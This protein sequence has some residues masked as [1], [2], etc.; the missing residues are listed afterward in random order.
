MKKVLSVL[1]ISLLILSLSG[2]QA[3]IM[4]APGGPYPTFAPSPSPPP[5]SKV[6][7][8]YASSEGPL[9]NSYH[10]RL[11]EFKLMFTPIDL[12]VDGEYAYPLIAAGAREIG[13]VAVTVA[14]GMLTAQ[15]QPY[16][17]VSLTQKPGSAQPMLFFF[18]DIA[19]VRTLKPSQLE[20]NRLSFDQAHDVAATLGF[21]DPKVLMFVYAM[22]CM[23]PVASVK[24]FS[25]TDPG[26]LARVEE[27]KQLM[28]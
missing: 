23:E 1:L 28:D 13:Q 4:P 8:T 26:Y 2:V 6:W 3:A 18:P 11:T 9:F 19:T 22:V 7:N 24:A 17:G 15:L 16:A 21:E 14:G 25:L 12:S 20:G 5:K 27:L 10:P